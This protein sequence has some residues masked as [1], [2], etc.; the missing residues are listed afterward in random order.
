MRWELLVNGVSLGRKPAG[1]AV[2]NTVSFD[3]TYA[4]GEVVAVGYT[5][6]RETG[7]TRLATAGP[8]HALRLTAD[9][10][11]MAAAYGDLIYVTVEVVDAAGAPVQYAADTITCQVAGAGE[12]TAIGNGGSV[13]GGA[14]RGRQ[15]PGLRGAAH[16][17]GAQHRR[18]AAR[19]A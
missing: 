4:P 5:A 6:G 2:K 1:A 8:A 7:R 14:V 3:V 10:P 16:G 11:A 18:H 17:R 19:S 15:P 12:L 9:R 13:L